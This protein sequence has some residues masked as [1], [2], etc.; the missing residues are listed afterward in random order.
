M[1]EKRK[2]RTTVLAHVEVGTFPGGTLRDWLAWR[3]AENQRMARELAAQ[4]EAHYELIDGA[5]VN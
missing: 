1:T 5:T 4:C 2:D 3:E